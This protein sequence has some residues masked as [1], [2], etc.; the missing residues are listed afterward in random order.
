MLHIELGEDFVARRVVRLQLGRHLESLG[1]WLEL[2]HS[3]SV[4]LAQEVPQVDLEILF[5]L[6]GDAVQHLAVVALQV[7]PVLPLRQDPVDR[8]EG[9]EVLEARVQATC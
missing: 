1:R 3:G 9:L 2:L 8:L 5:A 7:L 6:A 4:D